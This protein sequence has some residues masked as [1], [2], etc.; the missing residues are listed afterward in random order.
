MAGYSKRSLAEKLGIKS[1]HRAYIQHPPKDYSELLDAPDAKIASRLTGEFDFVHA[2]FEDAASFRKD[3]PRLKK[4]LSKSGMLWISWRKG[5]VTDL[6]ETIV[7]DEALEAG[8][9][10]VKVCAVDEVWSG[11]K[12]VYRLKDRG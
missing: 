8:L 11:L 5:K 1:G 2:F 12:L 9:V 6:T 10:D 7:R 4:A 3:L